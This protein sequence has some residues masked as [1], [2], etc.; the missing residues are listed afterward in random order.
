LRGD[1]VWLSIQDTVR[2]SVSP[3]VY[4][5][6]M[7]RLCF[8]KID[9][10][11]L[12]VKSPTKFVADW[13][14]RNYSSLLLDSASR[15]GVE[16]V[17]VSV[18][19]MPAANDAGRAELG[20]APAAPPAAANG[21]FVGSK[22]SERFSFDTFVQGD[23]NALAVAALRRALG[24]SSYNPIVVHANAGQGK[25]HLLQAFANGCAGG[26]RRAV[27]STA[28]GFVNGFVK[29]LRDRTAVSFKEDYKSAEVLVVDDVQFFAGKDNISRELF[30][31]VDFYV[32][33]GRQVVVSA[34]A[35][36]VN[37]EGLPD[38]LK[39]RLSR[40]LVL[41][42]D[43]ADYGLRL[44]FLRR[45]A[46]GLGLEFDS[47][48]AEFLASKISRS[49]A[50][51]EGALNR[52]SARSVLLGEKPTLGG[53]RRAL[54]DI[55]AYNSRTVSIADIKKAVADRW[56]VAVGEMDGARKLRSIAVPRMVAMYVARMLTTK[57]L[58]ELGRAFGR[59]H[60]TILHAVRR[61]RQMIEVQPALSQI[62][63]DIE[64]Q[65]G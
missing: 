26:G 42:M 22:T 53:I 55:L 4:A 49:P 12:Y 11:T 56:G 58:P 65:V 61:V 1:A 2:K 43:D 63:D 57:S 50:E 9:L 47:G 8:D 35:A 40:G 37:I 5:A 51:I 45:R 13:V 31:L 34:N 48:V 25:T 39:T 60:A 23:G 28:D 7:E 6:W 16:R 17:S 46:A 15:Y 44:E 62:I 29:A 14:L 27:Y 18:G 19:A 3:A 59:D 20:G 10:G 41:G 21:F 36:P 52:L 30:H 32:S 24:D 33:N 54:D 64:K 38:S